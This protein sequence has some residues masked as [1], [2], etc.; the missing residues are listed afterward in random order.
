LAAFVESPSAWLTG[1][2]D[3]SEPEPLKRSF[4]LLKRALGLTKHIKTTMIK[5]DS[6]AT[7]F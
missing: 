6:F 4:D 3:E 2:A 1:T 5:V 7:L